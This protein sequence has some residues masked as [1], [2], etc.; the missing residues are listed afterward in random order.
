MKSD[1]II[2]NFCFIFLIAGFIFS[3]TVYAQT[4]S[5][6]VA[7]RIIIGEAANQGLKGMI[8]VGEVIRRRNSVKAF[9]GY[10]SKRVDQQPKWAWTMAKKAWK[11][12]ANTDYTNGADHFA[13]VRHF[14][15]PSWVKQSVKTYEYKDH[16]FYKEKLKGKVITEQKTF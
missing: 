10:T 7:E 15:P 4:I 13:N 8:C 3:E 2:K 14:K 12:S 6:E 9:K 11:L 16:V 5:D 1:R